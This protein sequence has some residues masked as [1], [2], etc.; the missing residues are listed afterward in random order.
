MLGQ[1]T[2]QFLVSKE[3]QQFCPGQFLKSK[4]FQGQ[5]ILWLNPSTDNDLI[6]LNPSKIGKIGERENREMRK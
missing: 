4:F 6:L 2:G 1:I 5:L 3:Q